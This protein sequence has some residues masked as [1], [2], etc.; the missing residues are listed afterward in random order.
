M[1]ERVGTE[2]S[3]AF[4]ALLSLFRVVVFFSE[5]D[6][7]RITIFTTDFSFL[8][9]QDTMNGFEGVKKA[10]SLELVLKTFQEVFSFF[11]DFCHS[12]KL[13]KVSLTY[14]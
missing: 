10:P 6:R 1:Q 3:F 11:T 4:L 9:M 14:M 5:E 13:K 8:C 12:P 7:T 2:K